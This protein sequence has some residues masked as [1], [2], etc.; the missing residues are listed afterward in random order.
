MIWIVLL[1]A[2]NVGGAGLTEGSVEMVAEGFR[3]TEGPVW[4]AKEGLLFTDIPADT[5]YRKDKSVYR[6][7]SGKANGLTL[8]T[9]GCLIACEH[10][11]RRVTRTDGKGTITVVAER[12]QGKRFNSPND[13]VVRSDGYIY[14]TDPPYG[15]EGREAELDFSGVYLVTPDGTV[16]LQFSMHKRPNG[17][18]LSPDEKVLYLGDSASGFIDTFDVKKDGTLANPR[19]FAECP[20]P[21]GMKVDANGNLW[22]TAGDGVRVYSPDGVL[23]ETIAFPRKPANCA[24]GD[25]DFKTL[26]VTARQGLYKVRCTVAGIRPGRPGK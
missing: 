4:L 7:P 11:N 21:D 9:K 26:Y 6:S 22:T 12:F 10:W 1:A 25:E 3:F 17:L 5:I 13:V 23:L 16:R 2:A 14:F 20:G 18:A 15:L 19:L 8:D 24:F